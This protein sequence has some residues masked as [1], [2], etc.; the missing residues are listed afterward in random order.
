VARTEIY[1]PATDT[2]SRGADVPTPLAA[3]G[4]AVDNARLYLIGGCDAVNCGHAD[5]Q[6]Y[7]PA[8]DSWSTAARYAEPTAWLA[9]GT[10]YGQIDCAG[11]Q[12][13]TGGTSDAFAYDPST[14]RWTSIAPL[15]IDLAAMSYAVANNR[16]LVVGGATRN[17]Q[18]VTN[19]G[20]SYDPD[21]DAWTALPNANV[22]V[23]RAASTCGLY[24][25]GGS[26]DG[27]TPI[28]NGEQLPGLTDCDG[29]FDVGWLAESATTLT[30][31]PGKSA[32]VKLTFDGADASVTQ[33]GRYDAEL[34]VS[35][36]TPYAQPP[37]VVTLTATPPKSWGKITGTVRGAACNGGTAPLAGAVVEV[38][39]S[40]ASYALVTDAS[41]HYGL[42]LDKR[43]NPLT[44]IAA[45]NG[46]QPQ[47]AGVRIAALQVTTRDLTLKPIG[48][49]S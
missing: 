45:A 16:L 17:L 35:T 41:G 29:N 19:E 5:V 39:G 25:V 14:D 11:G 43:N 13:T 20:F 46:W 15:P 48:A 8:A 33:P 3:S 18:F 9:C 30:L 47:T 32:S 26:S 2:W 6:V 4:V 34:G 22:A 42:W 7:D 10:L 27:S 23:Y 12:T 38:D 31:A 1:D 49:C 21:T 36:D 28:V 40:D 37:V 44:L 24:T